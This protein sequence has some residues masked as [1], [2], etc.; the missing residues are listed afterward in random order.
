M[1][2][3]GIHT[4][5]TYIWIKI[6][7]ENAKTTNKLQHI[8]NIFTAGGVMLADIARTSLLSDYTNLTPQY[9]KSLTLLPVSL[10]FTFVFGSKIRKDV[11]MIRKKTGWVLDFFSLYMYTF[12]SS[13]I[14]ASVNLTFSLIFSLSLP[15]FFLVY[16]HY[17][18]FLS[19]SLSF[20]LCIP[21]LSFCILVF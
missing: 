1:T 18:L 12:F 21:S 16:L 3:R 2:V 17:F 19:P 10:I 20:G 5:N 14:S 8:H 13:F 7:N 11:L 6:K 9:R 4:L 15:F